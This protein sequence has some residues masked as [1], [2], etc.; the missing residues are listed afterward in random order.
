M[1]ASELLT[2]VSAFG[3]LLDGPSADN[4]SAEATTAPLGLVC[5]AAL[6]ARCSDKHAV[7]RAKAL[8][9]RIWDGM[10]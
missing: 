6:A 10:G 4:A 1:A 3:N 9:V 7:V 2:D 8:Q 5:L